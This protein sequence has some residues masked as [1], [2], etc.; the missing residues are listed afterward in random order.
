MKDRKWSI[1]LVLVITGALIEWFGLKVLTI[2]FE[3]GGVGF[4]GFFGVGVVPFIVGLILL[5]IGAILLEEGN[6]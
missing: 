6:K 4:L 3:W 1:G 5:S 2:G